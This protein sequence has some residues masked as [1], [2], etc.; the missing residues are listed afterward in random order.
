MKLYWSPR[1]PFVRKAMVCAYEVGIADRI[2]KVYALVSMTQVNPDVLRV[3][4][5]GRIPALVT[6]AG[7]VLYDSNVICEYFDAEL[8]DSS[9]FPQDK[10]ERWLALT[11]L[12][13]A[14]GMLETGVLWR[15]ERVKPSPQQSSPTILAY[16]RKITSALD[17]IENATPA[18][19]P[20][21]VGIG[22]IG[23]AVAL[24]YLDFR[25]V[26]ID[27]RARVPRTARWFETFSARPS[28]QA[29]VPYE[30]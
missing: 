6:D 10:P 25:F 12:A 22:D 29:T 17:A 24:G 16:E 2:E 11:R 8:G 7:D 1:S 30:E 15:S 27:W 19:D 28:M 14:D 23:L 26:D 20:D 5:V 21:Y 13:L 4:P 18:L 9:L 3:N